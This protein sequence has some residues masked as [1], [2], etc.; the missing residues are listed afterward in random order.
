MTSMRLLCLVLAAAACHSGDTS[1][2]DECDANGN[3]PAGYECRLTDHTCTKSGTVTAPDAT[4]PDA[5]QVGCVTGSG[6]TLHTT[7]SVTGAETWTAAASPHVLTTDVTVYGTLTL[8]PCAVLRIAARKTITLSATGMFLAEG[9][10]SE[11]IRIGADDG[12]HPFAQIRSLGAPI[13]LAHVTAD[14]GGEPLNGTALTT[15]LFDVQGTAG[16]T[17]PLQELLAV[18]HVTITSSASNGI[19]LRDGAGFTASSTGLTVSGAAQYPLAFESRAVGSTPPGTYTGNGHDEILLVGVNESIIESTTIHERG[20][21][22]RVGLDASSG[23]LRVTAPGGTTRVTT[24]T[25][26]PGVT[27]RFKKSGV[28]RLEVFTGPQP[29]LAALVAV[30]TAERPIVF[31]SAAATPAAGD[32]LGIYY[33]LIPDASNRVDHARVEYAGGASS[34]GSSSCPGTTWTTSDAAVRIFGPPSG[35]FITNTAIVASAAHGIDRG[36]RADNTTDFLASNTFQDV[37]QCKQTYPNTGS[38]PARDMVP[39]PR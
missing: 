11:P 19:Q 13:R 38:C 23:E 3:C 22:Y 2:L 12:A 31:T 10:A 5:A 39:C 1:S 20:V 26:E 25:I 7:G 30:G 28:L 4:V 27:L 24:L 14:G 37:A 34:S 36:W 21:P 8:E 15:G 16:A 35:A 32:W 9:T 33:G 17:S 18:D 29:A 6:P